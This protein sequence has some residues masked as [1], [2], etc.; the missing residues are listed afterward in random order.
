MKIKYFI[1][2]PVIS[3][4]YTYIK[5]GIILLC[6]SHISYMPSIESISF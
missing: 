4:I 1:C 2:N 6:S 3:Y 5:Q